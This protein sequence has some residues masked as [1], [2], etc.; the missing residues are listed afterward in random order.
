M[1]PIEAQLLVTKTRA[2]R[3][4]PGFIARPRLSQWLTEA[5]RHGVVLLS[6]PAGYGKTT[7]L[8]EALQHTPM[9]VGWVSLDDDD[10]D[11]G[12]FWL[13]VISA[14]ETVSTETCRPILT[15]LQSPERPPTR[16]LLTALV[17]SLSSQG[18]DFALVLDDYQAIAS[19]AIHDGIGFIGEHLPP[20]LHLVI[21]ARADP[22]LPLARW[23]AR[24]G[25]AEIRAEELAFTSAEAA[26]FLERNTGTALREADVTA[27]QRRSEG[28]IAG[29]KMA[30]LTLTGRKDITSSIKAFSGANRFILEFLVEEVLDRQ[31]PRVRRF[32]LETSVV[33]RL[34][35]PLCNAM[36]GNDDG[37]SMLEQLESANLFLTPLDDE[38]RWYRY[39]Q[40]FAD[41][42]RSRL[43]ASEPE[44]VGVLHRRA[45][46]WLEREGLID[47][48]IE[49]SLL[50]GDGDRAV[51]L[52][53]EEAPRMLAQGQA[54]RLLRYTG[55][56]SEPLLL[57][58]PW[59]CVSFA[60]AALM[61]N[62][63]E[64][65]LPMLSR[66]VTALS[67]V[68][69]KMTP[70]SRSN[71]QRIKGHLLS[72][73]SF[74][75]RAQGDIPRATGLSEE[76][77]R[78]L[79][80]DVPG[81]RVAHAVNSLNLAACYQESGDIAM[82]VSFLEELAT[83]GRA[84]GFSYAALAARAS[85]AEIEMQ[86]SRL[87]RAAAICE[88]A[89]E[90]GR[91]WGG[92]GPM[93]GTALSFIVRGRIQYER[94][95]LEGAAA[96]L[97]EG[98][99]LGEM[100]ENREPVLKGY[101]SMAELAQAKGDQDAAVEWLDRAGNLGP[102]VS[103]PPELGQLPARKCKV[104]LHRGDRVAATNWA[105]EQEMSLPMS[106]Q[107]RYDQE[108]AWLTLVRVRIATGSCRE[109]PVYLDAFIRNAERQGRTGAVIEG[110]IL[111]ALCAD[112]SGASAEAARSFERAVSLA[113]PAGYVRIFV[114]EGSSLTGLLRRLCT[115][116]T[117]RDY[118]TRLLDAMSPEGGSRPGVVESLSERECEVL[119]LIAAGKSNRE[120]ACDL[121]LATGTVK[122]HA[123]NIFGKLGVGSRT[124]AVA[125]ARELGILKK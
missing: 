75:A 114:D 54:A 34:S 17:N 39:H 55:R 76:A 78:E 38:R 49:H 84:G 13:Y 81:D 90:Q 125:R 18:T 80:G 121:F 88:E 46:E 99:E 73:Q 68:P 123:N 124:Q 59:L 27:L 45:S 71:V 116:G 16:W 104:A 79:P 94:N 44:H 107:P 50:G 77:N 20:H 60:W 119:R 48:A 108:L 89:I 11:P 120:I 105:R 72:I 24:G 37:Q 85:L 3:L 9:P 111:K 109:L 96:S 113:E 66:T 86:L 29:L 21:A 2:P 101:L 51:L 110:L 61:A 95:D 5:M 41:V 92:A 117:H 102:W 70:C 47:G 112:R 33:E 32:L 30:A 12:T 53:E 93:P 42:L 115:E 118:A 91:R 43:T 103:L 10:N 19:P 56:I 26:A 83:A 35:G 67:D 52:L 25:L 82:A 31:S 36:T 122:K 62:N 40:L 23:R 14:L 64:L 58:S 100:S 69:E 65:L 74:V 98:I 1:P 97:H 22:P 7:L 63:Q 4:P 87:D 28:W 6:A 57:G 8:A 15:A 106:R